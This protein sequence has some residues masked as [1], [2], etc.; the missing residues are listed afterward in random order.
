MHDRDVLQITLRENHRYEFVALPAG[1][2]FS[3]F[4]NPPWPFPF[5]NNLA[6]VDFVRLQADAAGFVESSY[7]DATVGSAWPFP[8]ALRRPE[9]GYVTRPMNVRGIE[10]FHRSSVLP[11]KDKV[12]VLVVYSRTW[13]PKYG[14]LRSPKVIDFL[15]RYYYYEPQITREEIE[16]Q[17]GLVQVARSERRGQWIEVYAHDHRSNGTLVRLR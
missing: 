1:L 12:E 11:L 17:L 5:E 6:A 4:W 14:I 10:D 15:T 3:L 2:V 7:P 9:F 8:D 16:T 13:E